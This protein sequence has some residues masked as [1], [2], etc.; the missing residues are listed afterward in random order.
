MFLDLTVIFT[1]IRSAPASRAAVSSLNGSYGGSSRQSAINSR[2]ELAIDTQTPLPLRSSMYNIPSK[3][4][5]VW[6]ISR[7]HISHARPPCATYDSFTYKWHH[8]LTASSWKASSHNCWTATHPCAF[9][10]Q[11]S[12]LVQHFQGYNWSNI[13]FL[14]LFLVC[15]LCL[16]RSFRKFVQPYKLPGKAQLVFVSGI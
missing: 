10:W 7:Q 5:A 11:I 16:G 15:H 14:E 1:F 9:N 8:H 2:P 6:I 4:F 3:L 12:L 13:C